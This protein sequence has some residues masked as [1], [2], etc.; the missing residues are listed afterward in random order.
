MIF[1]IT[2]Y[3]I[4]LLLHTTVSVIICTMV[5]TCTHV[6]TQAQ[7]HMYT[8]THLTHTHTTHNTRAHTHT[9]TP[10]TERMGISP[11]LFNILSFTFTISYS[12]S[13]KKSTKKVNQIDFL[14]TKYLTHAHLYKHYIFKKMKPEP[15]VPS[16]PLQ[17]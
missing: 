5:H 4:S 13:E 8:H 15:F 16:I 9:H 14:A 3:L 6:C 1:R 12:N 7:T 11:L 17:T 10:R 2:F